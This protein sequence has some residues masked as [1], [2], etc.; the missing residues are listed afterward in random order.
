MTDFVFQMIEHKG[1]IKCIDAGSLLIS[2]GLGALGG[3]PSGAV[4]KKVLVSNLKKLSN[5][6]KKN[7]GEWLSKQKHSLKGNKHLA[8]DKQI[9]GNNGPNKARNDHFFERPNGT[10]YHVEAK[11]GTSGLTPAQ[12]I[13]KQH[14]DSIDPSLYAV[15]YWSYKFFGKVG[16]HTGAAISGI[17]AGVADLSDCDC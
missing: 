3:G 5:T 10:Q 13:A 1:N 8:S 12:R 14:L 15:D 17:A 6:S 16:G 4:A 2:G 7:I 9:F 11:F